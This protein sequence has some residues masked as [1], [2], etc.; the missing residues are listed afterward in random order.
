MVSLFLVVSLVDAKGEEGAVEG[1]EMTFFVFYLENV[2]FFSIWGI[3]VQILKNTILVLKI[4]PNYCF[5]K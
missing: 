5:A 4:K 1:K 3:V 2:T